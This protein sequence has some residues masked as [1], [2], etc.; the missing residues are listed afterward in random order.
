MKRTEK[1]VEVEVRVNPTCEI[2]FRGLRWGAGAELRMPFEE[3]M[4]S[5]KEGVVS[6]LVS[7]KE[8]V[9]EVVEETFKEADN[10]SAR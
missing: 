3:A 4:Q 7:A 9:K 10:G 6:L 2:R 8:T 1:P 5:A